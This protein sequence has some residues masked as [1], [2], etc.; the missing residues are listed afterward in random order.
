M[1]PVGRREQFRLHHVC[2]VRRRQK[3]Q[4][5]TCDLV[6]GE[7]LYERPARCIFFAGVSVNDPAFFTETAIC[8]PNGRESA[9]CSTD[10]KRLDC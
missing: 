1:A 3:F 8:L 7:L 9:A 2:A 6:M 5:L 4:R 10:A